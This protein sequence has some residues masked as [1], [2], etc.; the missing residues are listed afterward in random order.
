MQQ[1]DARGYAANLFDLRGKNAL[2]TGASSGLGEHFAQTL[3]R[4]GARVA[5]TARN[6][7]RLS[8]TSKA[9]VDAGGS[10][11]AVGM[12]VTDPRSV[13]QA[14]ARVIETVGPVHILINNAGIAVTKPA[15]EQDED[16]WNSVIETNL[17][18]AWRVAR[19]TAAHMKQHGQGGSIVNI[20]SVLAQR[21]AKQLPAYVAAKA[22]L[23][24]LTRALGIELARFGIRVN[25]IAP[26]YIKT[27]INQAFFATAAGRAIIEHNPQRRLGRPQD[28][29][30]VLLL[31]ASD[32][33]A[34]M[35]STVIAVDGGHG[36]VG[37]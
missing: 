18:G 10:A 3:A 6:E 25:A 1:T 31:L 16:D 35:T 27:E 34:H 22:G 23:A 8:A 2:V 28:L 5:L 12:D 15:L 9:I 37:I 7:Q 26:G 32:A 19:A 33:S 21:V 17:N 11:V 20:V 4:A 14:M 36:E 30:G 24:H 29:D 13:E